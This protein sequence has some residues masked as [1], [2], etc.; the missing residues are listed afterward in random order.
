MAEHCA[1]LG[2]LEIPVVRTFLD[3]ALHVS[4]P[5]MPHL[6]G[7]SSAL[8]TAQSGSLDERNS[9]L[10]RTLLSVALVWYYYYK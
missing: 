4:E 3:K 9:W 2:A 1:G 10:C 7:D 5:Q 6:Y 8:A